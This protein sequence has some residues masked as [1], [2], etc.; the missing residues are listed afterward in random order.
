MDKNTAEKAAKI[1]LKI[2]AITLNPKKPYKY[3]SGILSPVYTDCRL[4][5]SYPKERTAIRD[6]YI[7]NI[8]S[9][10]N[11]NVIAGTATAGIPHAA[12]I[13][14]KMSLPLIYVRGK[15]KDHGKGNSIEGNLKKGDK[16]A[17]IEDLISTGSSSV[18]CV[19]E[20]RRQKGKASSIFSIIT[21]GMKK[22]SENFEKNN[23][24]LYSLTD[25]ETVVKIAAKEEYIKKQDKAIILE[26]IQDPSSWGKKM[27]FK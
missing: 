17:V 1:L 7:K 4:L 20:I 13:A 9:L 22:A 16:I 10:R 23:V 2:G 3:S 14:E 26:W 18:D 8:K 11:F 5:I 6:L 27:S 25:F 24:K 12:W 15:A 19:L 21:Y